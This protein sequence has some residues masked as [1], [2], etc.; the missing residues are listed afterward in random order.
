MYILIFPDLINIFTDSD[1]DVPR[2]GKPKIQQ[3]VGVYYMGY[4]Q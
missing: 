3:M 4:I 2:L 1:A